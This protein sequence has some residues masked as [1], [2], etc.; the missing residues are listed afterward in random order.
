VLSE[1][2]LRGGEKETPSQFIRESCWVF[3]SPCPVR[4]RFVTL[5]INT[6]WKANCQIRALCNPDQLRMHLHND[7]WL[8]SVG[9]GRK[10]LKVWK[11]LRDQ[12][13]R[14][15]L[16]FLLSEHPA[17]L[18][19]IPSPEQHWFLPWNLWVLLFAFALGPDGILLKTVTAVLDFIQRGWCGVTTPLLGSISNISCVLVREISLKK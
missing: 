1:S 3:P 6:W 9:P 2:L 16:F 5:R 15:L 14:T 10:R 12:H 11:A 18:E 8:C 19:F 4:R 13:W 7:Y 17:L